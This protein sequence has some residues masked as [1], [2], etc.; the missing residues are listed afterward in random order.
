MGHGGDAKYKKIHISISY[1]L[2]LKGGGVLGPKSENYKSNVLISIGEGGWK[3]HNMQSYKEC[4]NAQERVG[5][6]QIQPKSFFFLQ[7]FRAS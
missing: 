1:V 5:I 4:L 2:I 6:R 7:V 3:V